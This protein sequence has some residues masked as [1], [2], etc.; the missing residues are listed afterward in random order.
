MKSEEI[1]RFLK[2]NYNI[3]V[4]DYKKIKNVYKISDNL[5]S[6][7]LKC[8]SYDYGHVLFIVKA[9]EHL[10]K[11][12]FD[13]IPEIIRTIK[14]DQFIKFQKGYVYLTDWVDSRLCNFDNPVDL[15][16][17]VKVLAE[18]HLKSRNFVVTE[19]MNPRV[20]WF[21]WIGNFKNRRDEILKFK[22]MISKKDKKTEFDNLYSKMMQE[23]LV[24][25][26]KS[27]SDIEKSEYNH[28]MKKE[29]K[30]NGFCHHDYAH[31][32]ILIDKKENI[33][34]ID[35]DYCILDTHLHDLS[36]ILIRKMKNGLWDMK[37]CLFILDT[38]NEKYTIE[39]SDIP[40]IAAF[41]EF[42]QGYWQVGLQYYVEKQPWTEEFFISRLNRLH[43]DKDERQEFVEELINLKYL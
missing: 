26:D 36:S 31:H 3:K 10:K 20:G 13:N 4:K 32:N 9:I 41:I 37:S 43:K 16:M 8:I 24:K 5:K 1:S 39:N 17:A 19:D 22:S 38:Y 34:I 40:I 28:K 21:K 29:F 14:G 12:G 35:F 11:N 2:D 42:P 30:L 23:E 15:K 33:N 6:Y 27:I 18:L 7:C 25:V